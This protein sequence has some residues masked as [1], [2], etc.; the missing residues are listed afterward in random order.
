M[1][2]L[3]K[4]YA[5]TFRWNHLHLKVKRAVVKN[6]SGADSAILAKGSKRRG[7]TE[8]RQRYKFGNCQPIW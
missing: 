5:G 6:D 3:C 4:G 2:T 8:K 7:G 1:P